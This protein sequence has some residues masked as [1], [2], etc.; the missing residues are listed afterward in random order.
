MKRLLLLP[1]FLGLLLTVS[2]TENENG[3]ENPFNRTITA[4]VVNGNNY[5]DLISNVVATLWVN[6]RN[7]TIATGTWSNGGFTITL[8]QTI[9]TALLL[10]IFYDVPQG[11]NVSNRAARLQ[12]VSIRAHDEQQRERGSVVYGTA[13]RSS[14]MGLLYADRDVTI[15][16]T[17]PL[18]DA[19]DG[20]QVPNGR[21]TIWNLQLRTGWNRVYII[22]KS[23]QVEY[24]STESISGLR[25][26][27]SQ[28]D[29]IPV[30]PQPPPPPPP[31]PCEDSCWY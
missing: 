17:E 25:W 12:G 11:L 22:A 14:Q 7:H 31:Y 19:T 2:C 18:F 21:Y 3:H 20:G 16:G 5:N 24:I 4:T 8:P 1:L 6:D 13:D 9:N 26:Y 23:E 30:P 27:F 29:D 10:P 15:T 28:G